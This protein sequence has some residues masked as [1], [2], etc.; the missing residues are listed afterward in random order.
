M[1][2]IMWFGLNCRTQLGRLLTNNAASPFSLSLKSS[3]LC[4]HHHHHRETIIPFTAH[5]T[6]GSFCHFLPLR[7]NC[8]PS[9]EG[10]SEHLCVS[11]CVWVAASAL[12]VLLGAQMVPKPATTA[13]TMATFSHG[14]P[15]F[16]S[17]T[18]PVQA[19]TNTSPMYAHTSR[20]GSR[21]GYSLFPYSWRNNGT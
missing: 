21:T 3:H 20:L 8:F 5:Q 19:W 14:T 12:G 18:P 7:P 1:L 6:P 17:P 15:G 2:K 13:L 4:Q 16:L 9:A 10:E 11:I